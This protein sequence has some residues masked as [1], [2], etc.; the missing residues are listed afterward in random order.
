MTEEQRDTMQKFT[1]DW[2]EAG[3][4]IDKEWAARFMDA[5]CINILCAECLIEQ[6]ECGDLTEFHSTGKVSKPEEGAYRCTSCSRRIDHLLVFVLEEN[7]YNVDLEDDWPHWSGQESVD[8]S[9]KSA[10]ATCPRCEHEF[11]DVWTGG[12]S[13]ESWILK[14]LLSLKVEKDE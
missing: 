11:D 7:R 14:L 4:P 2:T 6:V 5:S 13:L 3:K 12:E 8:A 1:K 9:E 10:T